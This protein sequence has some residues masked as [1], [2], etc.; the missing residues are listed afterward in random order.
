MQKAI[1]QFTLEDGTPFLV[2]VDNPQGSG[3]QRT[4]AINTGQMVYQAKMTLEQALEQVKPV[5]A[6]VLSRLK[7]GLTTPADEIEVTFG[8]KLNAEAGAIISS[9]GGEVT[10]EVKLKWNREKAGS[11]VPAVTTAE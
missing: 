7:T 1:A 3:I 8:L 9:V 2:E 11:E 6:T 4:A 5:A 10:F